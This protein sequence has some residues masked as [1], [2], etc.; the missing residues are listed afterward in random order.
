MGVA[1]LDLFPSVSKGFTFSVVFWK[2]ISVLSV[3]FSLPAFV[4][5]ITIFILLRSFY[6]RLHGMKL[7]LCRVLSM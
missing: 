3:A 4:I 5:I 1:L 2:L 6:L 7:M